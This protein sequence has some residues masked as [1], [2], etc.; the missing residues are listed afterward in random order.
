MDQF[1]VRRPALKAIARTPKLPG[2][3]DRNVTV[4]PGRDK[5]TRVWAGATVRNVSGLGEVSAYGLPGEVG[6]LVVD[7]PAGS[8]AAA[9]GLRKDDVIFLVNGNTVASLP[10]LL[11]SAR[12]QTATTK[13]KVGVFRGQRVAEMEI[14]GPLQ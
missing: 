13:T 10:E 5:A 7:A 12:G 14:A 9:A 6:V 8:A 1:G 4:A 3:D 11:R 2:A